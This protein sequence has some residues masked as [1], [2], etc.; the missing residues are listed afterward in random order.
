MGQ[1]PLRPMA[2]AGR[3][4]VRADDKFEREQK[5]RCAACHRPDN[6][7]PDAGFSGPVRRTRF[8]DDR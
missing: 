6:A 7:E 5:V 1:F 3:V 8:L 4:L 2:D